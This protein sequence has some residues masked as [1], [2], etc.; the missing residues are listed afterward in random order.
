MICLGLAMA[1]L[2]PFPALDGGRLMF[3]L[4]EVILGRRIDQKFEGFAHTVGFFLLLAVLLYV[5]F[6]DFIKPIPL[7]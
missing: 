2:L 4:A 1:N 7:P 5:N 3:I 6:L